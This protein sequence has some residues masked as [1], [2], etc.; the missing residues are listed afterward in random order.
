MTSFFEKSY[1]ELFRSGLIQIGNQSVIH[2]FPDISTSSSMTKKVDL[3]QMI[4]FLL[5]DRK[6]WLHLL[7]ICLSSIVLGLNLPVYTVL[8]GETLNLIA[9]RNTTELQSRFNYF[10]TM[11]LVAGFVA[12]FC[13]IIQDSM[14]SIVESK[15]ATRIRRDTLTL[16]LQKKVEWFDT[17]AKTIC[18]MLSILR[19]SPDHQRE[20]AKQFVFL[21]ETLSSLTVSIFLSVFYNWKLGLATHMFTPLILLFLYYNRILVE[22]RAHY[23]F[24]TL[25]KLK[26]GIE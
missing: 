5:R 8:F 21:L 18:E 2:Q 15:L 6:H 13:K 1:Q 17:E 16:M 11:F 4:K 3:I 10:A 23:C 20:F 24:S 26:K 25:N 22:Q 12:G 19:K 14:L 9:M 7:L